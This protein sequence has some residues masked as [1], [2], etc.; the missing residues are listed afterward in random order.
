MLSRPSGYHVLRDLEDDAS[1]EDSGQITDAS[2]RHRHVLDD[3]SETQES[4]IEHDIGAVTTSTDLETG[5]SADATLK[6]QFSSILAML[7]SSTALISGK[8]CFQC[9][10]IKDYS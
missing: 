3:T 10:V 6:M 4:D 1:P 2:V 8:Q 7:W 9:K 5:A